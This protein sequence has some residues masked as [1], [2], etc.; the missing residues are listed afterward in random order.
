MNFHNRELVTA[1]SAKDRGDNHRA[2]VGFQKALREDPDSALAHAHYAHCLINM[3]KI[4]AA[5]READA[6]LAADAS[7]P[8]A[9]VMRA[10]VDA[11]FDDEASAQA[12]L[13]EAL[14][15]DP[16]NTNALTIRCGIALSNHDNDALEKAVTVLLSVAPQDFEAHFHASRLASRRMDADKAEHHAREAL[17]L[18]PNYALNHVA[19]GWAFWVRKEFDVAR[20]AALSGLSID[21]E[22]IAAQ[23]LL[24]AIDMHSAPLTGWFNRLG[25]I[26]DNVNLRKMVI[27]GAPLLFLYVTSADVLRFFEQDTAAT[28]I[29][30]AVQITGLALIVSTQLFARKAAGY[31]KAAVLRTDY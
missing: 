15:L 18:N 11:I 22:N 16:E 6:A 21:P 13:N 28:I 31:R 30:R 12:A 17:R 8:L 9:H 5:S 1:I 29:N 20:D 23:E 3:G 7:V 19:I 27:Y 4:F 10:M 14:R 25:Y 24:A 26:L 2:L